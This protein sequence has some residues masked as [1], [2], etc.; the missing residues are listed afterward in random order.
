MLPILVNLMQGRIL[1]QRLRIRMLKILRLSMNSRHFVQGLLILRELTHG[2]RTRKL[3]VLRL[4]NRTS[5]SPF[6]QGLH[7]LWHLV[8]GLRIHMPCV[9]M[10]RTHG[11]H[12]Y[13]K[14]GLLI[15]RQLMQRHRIHAH[16]ILRHPVHR[17]QRRQRRWRV[18]LRSFRFVAEEQV[19]EAEHRGATGAIW[20]MEHLRS[21]CRRRRS[22]RRRRRVAPGRRS[23][24]N[25]VGH[26][27]GEHQVERQLSVDQC[28][29]RSG[30]RRKVVPPK[31]RHVA[32]PPPLPECR[33][34]GQEV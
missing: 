28:R 16:L 33:R 13:L 2:H 1:V 15:P 12:R 18:A 25:R 21:R 22:R 8:Q 34:D 9:V 4:G 11:V 29:N 6:M 10:L 30:D 24:R 23:L 20:I 5:P 7:L 31:G 3:L 32:M 17:P 14:R 27:P 26:Q 19:D